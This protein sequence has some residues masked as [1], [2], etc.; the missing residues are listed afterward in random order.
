[1][2]ISPSRV[3]AEEDRR[4]SLPIIHEEMRRLATL[5]QANESPISDIVNRRAVELY[6]RLRQE[7]MLAS[8]RTYDYLTATKIS[9]EINGVVQRRCTERMLVPEFLLGMQHAKDVIVRW[10]KE[11]PLR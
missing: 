7:N 9:E 8:R 11:R 1:M 5:A 10:L 2:D 4:P 6:E 3:P